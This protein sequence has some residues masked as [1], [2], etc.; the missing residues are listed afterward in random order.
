MF[1][2]GLL[3]L[4][5]LL[6]FSFVYADTFKANEPVSLL[7]K[8]VKIKNI[9]PTSVIISVDNVSG[10]VSLGEEKIINDVKIKVDEIFFVDEVEG[11]YVRINAISTYKCGDGICEKSENKEN[12]C[13]DCGCDTSFNC[14]ENVCVKKYEPECSKN[15]DC[16]DN[17][18]LTGDICKRGKCLHLSSVQC[19]NDSDCNDNNE[20]TEDKCT[21]NECFNEKI[22]DCIKDKEEVLEEKNITL[23]EEKIE[24]IKVK[25][26]RIIDYIV[27]YIKRVLEIFK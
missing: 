21:N 27:E 16:N 15:E 4:I 24:K 17:N 11:R 12:C 20:C 19:S 22:I 8:I 25:E 14:E 9:R 2:K 6:C 13:L 7:G 5:L 23:N 1:K 3:I 18:S 26:K 10:I